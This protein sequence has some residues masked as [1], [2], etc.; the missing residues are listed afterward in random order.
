MAQASSDRRSGGPARGQWT[1]AL[2]LSVLG[3]AACILGGAWAV[4]TAVV[5]GRPLATVAWFVV[6]V[7]GGALSRVLVT[8]SL[9]HLRPR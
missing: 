2:C 8:L 5:E 4:A 1:V 6:A 7:T 9:R 3:V